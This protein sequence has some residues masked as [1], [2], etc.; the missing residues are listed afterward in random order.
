MWELVITVGLQLLGFFLGKNADNKKMMELFYKFVERIQGLYL[1]SA[2]L[3]DDAKARMK[4][5]AEK[6]FVESP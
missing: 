5:L 2:H 1:K 4:A 6:P 3:R